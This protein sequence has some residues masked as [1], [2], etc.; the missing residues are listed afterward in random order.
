MCYQSDK[1]FSNKSKGF[2]G[3]MKFDL[4]KKIIDEIEGKIEAVT[5]ASRGEPTL[6]KDLDKCLKYC[7]GKFLG[8][9]LNT[10]ATMLNEKLIHNLL[11]SDLQT[12]V[13]SIDEKDKAVIALVKTAWEAS[14]AEINSRN[15][16][17]KGS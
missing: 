6:Y 1:T 11:S 4:F 13:L 3:H 8:L 5:F 14:L 17:R 15:E 16:K 7:E 9:K 10:N 2:M 12:L